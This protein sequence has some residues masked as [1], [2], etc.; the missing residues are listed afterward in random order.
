MCK[1]NGDCLLTVM[2]L[3]QLSSTVS[4]QINRKLRGRRKKAVEI[5]RR[6]YGKGLAG[7]LT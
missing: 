3:F 4:K 5:K 2:T 6:E 7:E 1:S